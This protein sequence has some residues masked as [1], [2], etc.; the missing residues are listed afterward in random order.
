MW[1]IVVNVF[2]VSVILVVLFAIGRMFD[3]HIHLHRPGH[4]H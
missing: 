1:A 2:V 3:V 4:K